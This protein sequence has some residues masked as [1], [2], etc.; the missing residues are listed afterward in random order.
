MTDTEHA[1][2]DLNEEYL[3]ISFK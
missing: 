3:C 1:T 2:S